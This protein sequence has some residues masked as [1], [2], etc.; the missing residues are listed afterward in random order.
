MKSLIITKATEDWGFHFSATEEQARQILNARIGD[1]I[2]LTKDRE[3]VVVHDDFMEHWMKQGE[4][5]TFESLDIDDVKSKIREML[6][7]GAWE[8]D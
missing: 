6:L 8:Q 4:H 2:V 3:F 7:Q 5:T 1:R